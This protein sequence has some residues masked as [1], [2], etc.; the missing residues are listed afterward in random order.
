MR[1][2]VLFCILSLVGIAALA[3]PAFYFTQQ[4]MQRAV[5]SA[6]LLPEG[7]LLACL[8]DGTC[9]ILDPTGSVIWS[10]VFV[11]FPVERILVAGS[12]AYL[13]DSS[14]TLHTLNVSSLR[15]ISSR[16]FLKQGEVGVK[17]SAVSGDGRFLAVAIRY[18]PDTS[19]KYSL[20]RL[21]VY[22]LNKGERVFER[23]AFSPAVLVKVF[24]LDIWGDFLITETLNVSCHLCELTDNVVEVY[25]LGSKVQKVSERQTGL[26][27]V[28]SISG[29]YL[30]VQRV[31]DN[32]LLLL[33][34]PDLGLVAEKKDMPPMRQAVPLED[35]FLLVSEEYD[36]WRCS[37]ALNCHKLS[38]LP[39]MSL[40]ARLGSY[41]VVFSVPEVRVLLR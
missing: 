35:G 9:L 25:R 32:S 1:A 11:G 39:P 14:G 37:L 26:S 31:Q 36:L 8:A 17:Y 6:T 40:V 3:Q 28:K 30:L 13:V 38:S 22:T 34:L 27:R 15:E 29:G 4:D 41:L 19:S 12:L 33:S 18:Y 23:D 16:K 10:H 21:V 7:M 5:T 2:Q 24:S 20:D